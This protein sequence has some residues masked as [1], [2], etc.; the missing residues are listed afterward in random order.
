MVPPTQTDTG[1]PQ[2][3]RSVVERTVGRPHYGRWAS[4]VALV[5]GAALVIRQFAYA[6]ID[7]AIIPGYLTSPV[8]L[9]GLRGTMLLTA[10]AMLLGIVV[11]VAIAIMDLSANPVAV[12]A[13]KFYLW[14]FRGVPVLV[15]LLLWFNIGL[16][17]DYV[18]LGPVYQG[19]ANALI[20]PLLA[21]LLGL[22]LAEG[23][24]MGEIV[25][26]GILAV[27]PGQLQAARALG[28]TKARAMR[29]IV[30]PQAMRVIVPPTGNEAIN[31]TKYTSLA[32]AVSYA[33][34]LSSAGKIY[35]SNF[36]IVELLLTITI[37]YLALTTVLMAV[38][39]LIESRFSRGYG[40][41]RTPKPARFTVRKIG[42]TA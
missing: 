35:A 25:R 42:V 34:L 27:D 40:S 41:R 15:Q 37:W 39:R 3:A 13:A 19:P 22:G 33:E 20:T 30:L 10:L 24:S 11:G 18:N 36:K 14:F 16:V 8:I 28:F 12:A 5:A 7:W 26:S 4:A 1:A 32:F 31:M 23:A 29:R 21:A 17:V 2:T 9:E 38:Q 6:D